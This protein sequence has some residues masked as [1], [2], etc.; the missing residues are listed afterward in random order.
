MTPNVLSVEGGVESCRRG[1]RDTAKSARRGKEAGAEERVARDVEKEAVRGETRKV[2]KEAGGERSVAEKKER[3][4]MSRRKQVVRRA[5]KGEPNRKQCRDEGD[6]V[7][8]SCQD[9][10]CPIRREKRSWREGPLRRNVPGGNSRGEK[11][12]KARDVKKEAVRGEAR[13][14]R[15]E[16]GKEE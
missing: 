6:V 8:T 3:H 7:G 14:V 15:K 10:Q 12:R 16:A 11:K 1:V 9:A 5:V 2:R 13:K 4:S